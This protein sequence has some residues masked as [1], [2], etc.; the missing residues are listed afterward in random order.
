MTH[1]HLWGKPRVLGGLIGMFH[2]QRGHQT[3]S[4]HALQASGFSIWKTGSRF[5]FFF[6]VFC[7]LTSADSP[8][9]L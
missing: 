1:C 7:F 8:R 3:T 9:I 5:L 2:N 4:S 6:L